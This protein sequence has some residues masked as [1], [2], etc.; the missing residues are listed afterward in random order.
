MGR[1]R[2]AKVRNLEVNLLTETVL[3]ENMKRRL[4]MSSGE[5]AVML[6]KRFAGGDIEGPRSDDAIQSHIFSGLFSNRSKSSVCQDCCSRHDAGVLE[7]QP[8]TMIPTDTFPRLKVVKQRLNR[9]ADVVQEHEL[10]VFPLSFGMHCHQ[11][12]GM[13]LVGELRQDSRTVYKTSSV[14]VVVVVVV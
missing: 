1:L 2:W 8:G 4:K 7:L 12:C 13:M 11:S 9:P 10:F 14:V 6:D 3:V 5:K